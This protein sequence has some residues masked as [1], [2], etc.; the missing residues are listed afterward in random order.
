[1]VCYTIMIITVD[2]CETITEFLLRTGRGLP[3][4]CA[5]GRGCGKCRVKLLSGVWECDGRILR[6]PCSA[7][8]CRTRLKSCVG[9]IEVPDD[10]KKTTV[11]RSWENSFPLPCNEAP[12]IAL[13]LG[14]TTIAGVRIEKGTVVKSAGCLNGQCAWGDNVMSRIEKAGTHF[15]EVRNALLDSCRQILEELEYQSACRIGVAGNTVMS[16]FLHGI[17]PAPI[18]VYPFRAPRLV[19]PETKEV[20]EGKSL[21]TVPALTGLLGGDVTA[22]LFTH[23]LAEGE[24]FLDLGTNC[25]MVFCT[26]EGLWG[27]S[28]AAGPAFE[29]AGVTAGSRAVTG[30]IDHYEGA[31]RYSVIGG[32]EPRSI[33]G[34]GVIDFLAVERAKGH[35]DKFGRFVSGAQRAEIAPGVSLSESDLSE[36][37][38]AKAALYSGIRAL[39]E[40]AVCQVKK[41]KLAGGFSP[42][43]NVDNARK[44]GLL[45]DVE[46]EI[47]GNT[48][49]AGAALAAAAP[50][51]AV[52]M[53][54][55]FSAIRELHLNEHPTFTELFTRGLLLP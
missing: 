40:T 51:T 18:G 7:T 34:S 52:G 20:F 41:I 5:L 2:T 49:L 27:S 38:K 6:A 4:V 50:G 9:T 46:T 36:V 54:R 32:G 16:C 23:P 53:E 30:A 39:E 1:M 43:L 42:F 26:P 37:L 11:L 33:C 47:C 21:V 24:L 45:P 8:A 22:G 19:F 15:A 14:S 48:S 10:E 13:D 28:A 35:L 25:E 3:S 29:G 55:A 44:T 17:D 12:V 31:G